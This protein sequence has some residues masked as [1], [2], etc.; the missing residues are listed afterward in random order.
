MEFPVAQGFA[1]QTATFL[2]YSHISVLTLVLPFTAAKPSPQCTFPGLKQ[3]RR[4]A[5]FL[6]G[7]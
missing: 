3:C 7:T 2:C 5:A 1:T 4:S 6:Q